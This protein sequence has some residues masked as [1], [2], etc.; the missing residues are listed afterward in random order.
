MGFVNRW[1]INL[2]CARTFLTR[3]YCF[4]AWHV[5]Y[6]CNLKCRFCDFHKGPYEG[7]FTPEEFARAYEKL[8]ALG[9]RV[10]NLGGGEPFMRRDLPEI[11]EGLARDSIL[12]INTNGTLIDRERARM[13]W[14][15]GTDVMN[16][17]IDFADPSRHDFYRRREGTWEKA[18]NAV[19]ILLAER[20][21]DRQVVTVQSIYCDEN[22]EEFEKIIERCRDVGATFATNPYCSS[23]THEVG[24]HTGDPEAGR[25]LYELKDAYPKTFFISRYAL[26]RTDEFFRSGHVGDCSAGRYMLALSPSGEIMPCERRGDRSVGNIRDLD[27]SEVERRLREVAAGLDCSEC[28][29]RERSEIEYAYQPLSLKM[30]R[31]LLSEAKT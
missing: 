11:I 2:A 14:D 22:R 29:A 6:R 5:T 30:I 26:D 17:S 15:A 23:P 21:T 12:L 28:Y 10:V 16:V 9:V 19:E 20:T 31:Y 27:P 13:C 25:R 7:E 3:K 18:W 1:K 24:L 8:K 4:V